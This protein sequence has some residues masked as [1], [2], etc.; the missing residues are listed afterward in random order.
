M[1]RFKNAAFAGKGEFEYDSS[2]FVKAAAKVLKKMGYLESV[3]EKGGA[4]EMKIARHKKASVLKELKIMSRPGL[5]VY[6]STTDL[7]KHKGISR[8]ILTTPKGVMSSGE[9][10]K[11][12]LG[13]EVIV[14]IW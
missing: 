8:Y 2:R 3:A 5:R 1:I 14:E 6:M 9:A 11:K 7:T 4:L 10:V 12:N 13:G